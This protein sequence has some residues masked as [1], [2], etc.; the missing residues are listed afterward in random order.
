M[1]FFSKIEQFFFI[2]II[3]AG[4]VLGVFDFPLI[5]VR[6]DFFKSDRSKVDTSSTFYRFFFFY[7]RKKSRDLYF[8]RK[9]IYCS[10]CIRG[11]HTYQAQW[12]AEVGAKLNTAPDTRPAALVE[13]KYA[14]AV[15][16]YEQTVGHVPKFLSKLTFFFLKHCGKVIIK[17]NRPKRYSVDL[18]QGGM[19][20]PAEF[21]F[22]TCNE[23]LFFQMKEKTL[24]EIVK[25]EEK[26]K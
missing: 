2:L 6:V 23:K 13:D 12:N 8:C 20:V 25:F 19:E 24:V 18:K 21:C 1:A 11:Y 9:R 4:K 22:K 3:S 14:I 10:C 16:H 26:R 5:I 15:K 7:I 17:V